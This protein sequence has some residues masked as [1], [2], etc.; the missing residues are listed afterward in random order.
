[1][2][3]TPQRTSVAHAEPPESY[4]ESGYANAMSPA[5]S[6]QE[7]YARTYAAFARELDVVKDIYADMTDGLTIYTVY[8]G[9]FREAT[10]ALYDI[11]DRVM[12]MFPACLAKYRLIRQAARADYLLPVTARRVM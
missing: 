10:D 6:Q 8:E 5:S 2:S 9:D 4:V 7:E 1:M 11:Y 12:D 3:N